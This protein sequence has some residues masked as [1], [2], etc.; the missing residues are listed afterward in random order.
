MGDNCIDLLRYA[1][2]G[3]VIR[4]VGGNA[5]NVAVQAARAGAEVEYF[6][7]VGDDENGRLTLAALAAEGVGIR[8]AVVRPGATSVT[9]IDVTSEGE[10]ILGREDFGACRGYAPSAADFDWILSA[11]HVH[12]GWLDDGGALRTALAERSRSVS[13]DLSVNADP[14]DLGVG[15]LTIA[16]G[17]LAG[18][19]GPAETLAR[20]WL[21]QGAQMAVVTRGAEGA[22]VVNSEG[23][24]HVPAEPVEAVDTTGA[25]DTF[26][27]AFLL[28]RLT[29]ASPAAAAQAGAAAARLTCLHEGGFPQKGFV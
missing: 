29:G 28:A 9:E 27:A 24:W 8:G 12:I 18:P 5:V 11:D 13:Q 25:G 2:G 26:I 22:T 1:A 19:P 6:G 16:F 10:R 17:S 4:R 3:R 7:A 15:G 21:D 14:R 23:T 20:A